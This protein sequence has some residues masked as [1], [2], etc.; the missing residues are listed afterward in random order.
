MY[1]KRLFIATGLI[2]ILSG[3]TVLPVHVTPFYA[4]DNSSGSMLE[5]PVTPEDIAG[6][7]FA[8]VLILELND[9]GQYRFGY[10]PGWV[11]YGTWTATDDV[12]TLT[13]DHGAAA[14]SADQKNGRYN[15]TLNNGQLLV[16]VADDPCPFRATMMTYTAFHRADSNKHWWDELVDHPA[17]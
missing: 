1:Y 6:K 12:L 10:Q 14:C 17:N 9:N 2:L 13:D 11:I 3:N 5:M 4:K 16:E 8:G 7:Y 15:Y